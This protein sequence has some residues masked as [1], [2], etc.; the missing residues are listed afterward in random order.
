MFKTLALT[1]IVAFAAANEVEAEHCGNPH[2]HGLRSYGA[3]RSYNGLYGH[4]RG[5]G[6]GGYGLGGYG[7]YGVRSYGVRRAYGD[8][9]VSPTRAYSYGRG[10]E[11]GVGYDGAYDDGLYGYGGYGGYGYGRRGYDAGYGV[12]GGYDRGYGIRKSSGSVREYG[13]SYGAEV[14]PVRRHYGGY[15]HLW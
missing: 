13:S 9:Y 12:R 6:Y 8:D 1:A 5:L 7:G 3:I 4:G 11:R 14:L 10:Y 2:R 15:G